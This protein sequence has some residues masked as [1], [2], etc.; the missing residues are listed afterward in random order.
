MRLVLIVLTAVAGML[1]P[2]QAGVNAELRRH[3][4]HPLQAASWNMII[5][6]LTIFAALAVFR[7]PPPSLA[8]LRA[9]PWWALTGGACGATIVLTMLIAAPKLGAALLIGCFVTGELIA[10]VGLDHFG[11]VGYPARP[12]SL[13]RLLGLALLIAGV[14]LVERSA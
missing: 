2:V 9:A 8:A 3:V 14:L 12:A 4:D 13:T 11:A 7:L 10:S 1:Q 5:S 6:A